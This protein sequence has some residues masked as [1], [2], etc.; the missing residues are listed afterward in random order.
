MILAGS[1]LIVG[2]LFAYFVMRSRLYRQGIEHLNDGDID[3]AIAIFSRVIKYYPQ[4]ALALKNR[5]LLHQY[6][7]DM[8]SARADFDRAVARGG[9]INAQLQT[10]RAFFLAYT[11]NET[12]AIALFDSILHQDP[13]YLQAQ[14]GKT[15]AHIMLNNYAQAQIE[16]EKG[17][18]DLQA[19]K[20]KAEKFKAHMRY[21]LPQ[22]G[23]DYIRFLISFESSVCVSLAHLVRVM[24][25]SN[26][27]QR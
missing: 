26:V 5:A 1:V 9:R 20:D 2:A 4:D 27:T 22:L 13:S 18:A 17:L 10:E 11:G 8:T 14:L 15:Q 21:E 24:K 6:K 25:P 3:G 16:A 23:G 12:E 19:Q 7:G